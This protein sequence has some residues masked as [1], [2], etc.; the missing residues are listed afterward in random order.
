[1]DFIN[2]G[3]EVEASAIPVEPTN[4]QIITASHFQGQPLGHLRG[5]VGA[6]GVGDLALTG[7]GLAVT[8]KNAV[9]LDP[10]FA[11][12]VRPLRNGQLTWRTTV[13]VT[14]GAANARAVV[15]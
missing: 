13:G 11:F 12:G 10:S 2:E 9:M 3:L 8:L 14:T 6:T 4:A 15:A 5:N 7:S 1:V